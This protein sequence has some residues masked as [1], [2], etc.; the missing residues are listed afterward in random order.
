MDGAKLGRAELG[1][2]E[3]GRAE[4]GRRGIRGIPVAAV[5]SVR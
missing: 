5:S 2:P 1:R 4:L 3:L